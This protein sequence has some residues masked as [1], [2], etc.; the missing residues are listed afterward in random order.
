MDSQDS[1]EFTNTTQPASYP[2]PSMN[3]NQYN[4][5]SNYTMSFHGAN[6]FNPSS[7]YSISPRNMNQFT[8]PIYH[9]SY[10]ELLNTPIVTSQSCEPIKASK[11][12][13]KNAQN[14]N[15]SQSS[16]PQPSIIKKDWS[17]E[18]EVALTEAWLHISVDADVGNN[19]KCCHVES[20]PR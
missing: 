1:A 15:T 12:R 13:A 2:M 11:K 14:S 10:Q 3:M 16:T 5:S 19:Q 20:R 8:P 17:I 7:A 18:E 9:V 4:P 6:Q